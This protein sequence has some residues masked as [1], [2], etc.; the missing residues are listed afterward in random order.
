MLH[1][2]EDTAAAG[3]STSSIPPTQSAAFK[4]SPSTSAQGTHLLNE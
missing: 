2:F 4:A 1:D 3:I